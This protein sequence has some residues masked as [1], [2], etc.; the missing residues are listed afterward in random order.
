MNDQK[1]PSFNKEVYPRQRKQ[2]VQGAR[3][4]NE[5]LTKNGMCLGA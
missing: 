1:K 5:P 2:L 4:W 3:G